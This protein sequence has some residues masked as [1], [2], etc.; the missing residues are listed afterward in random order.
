MNSPKHLV[1]LMIS[2]LGAVC[3]PTE[4][5]AGPLLG[6]ADPYAVLAGTLV[7]ASGDGANIVGNVG[8]ANSAISGPMV[9]TN[10]TQNNAGGSAALGDANA[11]AAFLRGIPA[12]QD[13]TGTDL[14]GRILKAGAY[15]FKTTAGLNGTLTLDAQSNDNAVFIFEIGTDLTTGS[16]AKVS[17]VNGGPHD[18]VYWLVGSQATL[19]D[20]TVFQ[21]NIIAGTAVVL[22]PS[23]Q[24]QCG[25]AIANTA[26]TMAG[27]TAANPTNLVSTNGIP[28]G[29]VGGFGG[30]YELS[31]GV[32]ALVDSGRFT[33]V[34]EG[35]GVSLVGGPVSGDAVS[36]PEPATLALVGIAFAGI[37]LSRHRRIRCRGAAAA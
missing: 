12:T 5:F 14:G 34:S 3:G 33:G 18:G 25:R 32:I 10:G 15:K 29:C 30:G 27:K 2:L 11:A 16:D 24:I 19:G 37:G 35:G 36:I 8:A 9:I 6:S 20:N 13:L 17:V 21:G 23:A 4:G 26:V 31:D 1:P 7:S 28:A 22:D